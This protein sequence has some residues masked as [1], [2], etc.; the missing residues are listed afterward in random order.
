[1]KANIKPAG[2]EFSIVSRQMSSNSEI[3]KLTAPT[4]R[5]I[6][7]FVDAYEATDKAI[8]DCTV[9]FVSQAEEAKKAQDDVLPHLAFMQSLL[10]KKGNNHHLVI[11]ARKKGNKIL[12]WTDYYDKYKDSLWESLRTMERRIA[13]Y[14]KDPSLPPPPPPDTVPQLRKSDRKALIDAASIGSEI[15]T[16]LEQGGDP[17]PFLSQYKQVVTRKRLDDILHGDEV[18]SEEDRYRK[19]LSRVTQNHHNHV[20]AL[21]NQLAEMVIGR[22]PDDETIGLAKRIVELYRQLRQPR[23]FEEKAK[24]EMSHPV[25]VGAPRT[26]GEK[27]GMSRA[28]KTAKA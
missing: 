4:F 15:V 24:L 13:Q 1:M 16:A 18:E 12:W 10:S 3:P 27:I 26:K 5:S 28:R 19:T 25:V 20:N 21:A 11:E 14:R 6:T 23:F 9:K 17:T 8:A 22:K 7:E 2:A